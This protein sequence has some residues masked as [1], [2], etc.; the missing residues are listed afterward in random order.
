MLNTVLNPGGVVDP[1]INRTFLGSRR[2]GNGWYIW[3]IRRIYVLLLSKEHLR[4]FFVV[5][6]L[7]ELSVAFSQELLESM[8]RIWDGNGFST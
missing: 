4:I 6:T 7:D 2:C 3:E 8:R 1:V 5:F